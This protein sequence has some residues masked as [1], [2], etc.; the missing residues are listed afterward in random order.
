MTESWGIVTVNS[1]WIDPATVAK[2]AQNA[3]VFEAECFQ[4][5]KEPLSGFMKEPI[6]DT[7]IVVEV[8]KTVRAALMRLLQDS[9]WMP[10]AVRIN[11]GRFDVHITIEMDPD[12]ENLRAHKTEHLERQILE[13]KKKLLALIEQLEEQKDGSP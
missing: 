6:P 10:R 3:A 13:G 4:S 9:S 2:G 12:I 1:F 7:Q 11:P 5:W 8:E